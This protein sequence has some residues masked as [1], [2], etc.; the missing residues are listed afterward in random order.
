MPRIP[1]SARMW[2]F[3]VPRGSDG[4]GATGGADLACAGVLASAVCV[5]VTGASGVKV[6][7]D[8]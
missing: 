2:R 3:P 8:W 5:T 6:G 4:A 1:S 7:P